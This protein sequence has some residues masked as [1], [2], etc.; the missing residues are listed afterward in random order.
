V[1]LLLAGAAPV[2]VRIEIRNA[3]AAPMQC[4][5]L[6]AHWYTPLPVATARPGDT[7]TL[8]LAFDTARRAAVDDPVRQL[9]LETLFCGRVGR[10]WE[11]HGTLDLRDLAERAA[12]VGVAYAACT[13]AGDTLR[14][15]PAP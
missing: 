3:T 10:A 14:C 13:D 2:P 5:I 12:S 6:A 7:A 15:A 4:Q 11:T 1:A 8:T 9:P